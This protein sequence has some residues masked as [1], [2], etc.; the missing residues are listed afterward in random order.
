M[1]IKLPQY[2]GKDNLIMLLICPVFGIG[3]NIINLGTAYFHSFWVFLIATA[4]AFAGFCIFFIIC[5]ATAVFFK[6]R[7]PAEN[8]M[9]TRLSLMISVFLVMTG[10]FLAAL[11]QL[12]EAIPFLGYSYDANA[13]AW[14]YLALGI[15]N[16]FLTFLMEGIANYNE[17]KANREE[18]EKLN[19]ACLEG[20]LQGLKSQVNP[21]FLFNSLNAL[22]SLIHEDERKAEEFLDEMSK[23][24][25]YMLRPDEEQL[26]TLET[27]LKF[28]DSYMHLLRARYG[29]AIDL[30][31][32]VEEADRSRLL[33]P[34][35]L[36][37]LIEDCFSRNILSKSNPLKII[38]VTDGH[39]IVHFSH[40]IKLKPHQKD[41][42]RG[43]GLEILFKKYE[44]LNLPLSAG[45]DQP[46][47]SK[48]MIPLIEFANAPL[49]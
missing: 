13:F 25:R 10:L 33:P 36:Q 29:S 23:V 12:Y 17:W 27:E 48:V 20:Q 49:P 47:W 21:H 22:S 4:L 7:Y 16:V 41:S 14:T 35:S 32:T 39:G 8:H 24:Y 28:L 19:Q 3:F 2:N 40:E 11:L 18:A 44:L 43:A 1:K 26:V 45:E 42:C 34:L 5:G 15:V 9:A 38:I 37:V 31:V 30:R 6:S 46:G